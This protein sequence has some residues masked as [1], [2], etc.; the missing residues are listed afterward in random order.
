MTTH[1]ARIADYEII[2]LELLATNCS[3]YVAVPPARLGLTVDRVVLKLIDNSGIA[4]ERFGRELRAFAAVASPYL[5]KLYDAGQQDNQLFYSMEWCPLG[6]LANEDVSRATVL[7]AVASAARAAHALH[8]AGMAHRDIQPRNV[9]VVEN[10]GKLRDLGMVRVSD[11]QS[12]MSTM[13]AEDALEFVD[14]A[15]I[16][17][18]VPSRATDLYA[19]GSTLHTALCRRSMFAGMPHDPLAAIRHV[20][21][22]DPQVDP[23]IDSDVAT[24]IARCIDS[25]LTERY[26]TTADLAD[27]LEALS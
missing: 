17:G 6:S 23:A 25:Q 26:A 9:L 7:R 18:A 16:T 11:P 22:H 19:L 2:E 20:L 3:F 13:P 27:A 1:A 5:V 15:L 14:P 12:S 21:R 24:I 4:F 8:D 10:G